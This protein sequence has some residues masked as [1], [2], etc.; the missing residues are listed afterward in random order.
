MLVQNNSTS[1]SWTVGTVTILPLKQAE[2]LPDFLDDIS[3]ISDLQVISGQVGDGRF[4]PRL[5]T[6]IQYNADGD[7]TGL[8]GS[9]GRLINMPD[10]KRF[11]AITLGDSLLGNGTKNLNSTITTMIVIGG[12]IT[13]QLSGN[14]DVLAGNY[15]SIFNTTEIASDSLN[16]SI[17][18]SSISSF[19]AIWV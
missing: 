2:I 19:R 9:D 11:R 5:P 14:H 18:P 13:F 10:A 17:Q 6:E 1:R 16:V 12:V 15:I 3:A 4:Q 7:V 8:V